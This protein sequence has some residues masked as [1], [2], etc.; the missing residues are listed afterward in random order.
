MEVRERPD[1]PG[2]MVLDLWVIEEW[3]GRPMNCAPEEH[4]EVRWF[5]PA[6]ALRLDLAHDSYREFFAGLDDSRS[7]R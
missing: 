5:S 6:E 4:D 7:E 3:K 1:T 2:G